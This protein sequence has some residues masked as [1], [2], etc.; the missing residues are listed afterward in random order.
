MMFDVDKYMHG[1]CQYFAIAFAEMFDG[2][3]CLWLDVDYDAPDEQH[4]TCLCHAYAELSDGLYVDAMGAFCNISVREDEYEFNE[5]HIVRLSVE[6]A[7]KQLRK[8]GVPYGDEKTKREVKEFLHNNMLCLDVR[9]VD[10]PINH[11]GVFWASRRKNLVGVVPYSVANHKF[12]EHTESV[13]YTALPQ[14]VVGQHGFLANPCW[15]TR[16]YKKMPV[17]S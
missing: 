17:L 4:S 7:K 10:G 8:L 16:L 15:Y 6:D 1:Y 3:V 5:Q 9:I 14:I 2:N 11:V 13:S 12:A